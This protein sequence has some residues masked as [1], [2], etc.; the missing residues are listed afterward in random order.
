[1]KELAEDLKIK[2]G[3]LDKHA[4]CAVNSCQGKVDGDSDKTAQFIDMHWHWR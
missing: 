4:T 3:K 2:E 1:M